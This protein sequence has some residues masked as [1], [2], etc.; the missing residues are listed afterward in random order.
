MALSFDAKT[1][2]SNPK[3]SQLTSS[4][5]HPQFAHTYRHNVPHSQLSPPSN[6][7]YRDISQPSRSYL[8]GSCIY[9]VAAFTRIQQECCTINKK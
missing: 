5:E 9:Y 3:Q 2:N 4:S 7:T 8:V 1:Y 6:Q